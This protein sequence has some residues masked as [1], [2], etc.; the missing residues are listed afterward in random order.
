MTLYEV[1]VEG[2]ELE[3]ILREAEGE[4]TPEL[5]ARLDAFMAGG[6]DKIQAAACVVRSLEATADACQQEA[7]R[8]IARKG[9][10]Q[11]QAARLKARILCAV[12][13]MGGKVKTPLFNISA[14]N[15]AP[16]ITI[17]PAAD[18]D[19][20]ALSAAHPGY[21]KTTHALDMTVLRSAVR[22]GIDLGPSVVVTEHQPTRYLKII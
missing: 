6:K 17:E 21:V 2:L 3:A 4:L 19:L 7:T 9:S 5:E 22:A 14:Q 11:S 20:K 12:D 18:C 16:S 1:T 13:V 15:A 8:L 10:N